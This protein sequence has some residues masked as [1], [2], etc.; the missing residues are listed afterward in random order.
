MRFASV[1]DKFN[2]EIPSP[3]GWLEAVRTCDGGISPRS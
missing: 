1:K 3:E 2:R